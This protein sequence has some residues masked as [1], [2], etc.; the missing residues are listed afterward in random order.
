MCRK[1]VTQLD[2]V[3]L[4]FHHLSC[5]AVEENASAVRLCLIQTL[6]TKTVFFYKNTNVGTQSNAVPLLNQIYQGLVWAGRA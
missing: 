3:K 4:H 6:I 5:D 1:M 2:G